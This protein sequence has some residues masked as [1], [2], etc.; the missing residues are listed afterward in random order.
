MLFGFGSCYNPNKER[1]SNKVLSHFL[2]SGLQVVDHPR[3]ATTT[4]VP[5]LKDDRFFPPE[6]TLTLK[7]IYFQ[8]LV[9]PQMRTFIYR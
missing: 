4:F 6:G 3:L 2:Q 7:F 9:M 5:L 8:V 1:F